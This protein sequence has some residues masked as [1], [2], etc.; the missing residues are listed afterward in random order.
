V[1]KTTGGGEGAHQVDVNVGETRL[2][3]GDWLLANL[4]M[5]VD[6]LPLARGALS[7]PGVDIFTQSWPDKPGRNEPMSGKSAWVGNAM[8]VLKH[9]SAVLWG[10]QRS[11][12]A[13]GAV[14]CQSV[15]LYDLKINF[16]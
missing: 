10:H 9:C 7:H 12:H 5:A 13:C 3:D 15:T 14:P 6:F 1:I 2:W 16:E 4:K 11:P 8:E